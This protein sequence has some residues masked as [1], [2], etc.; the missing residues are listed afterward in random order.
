M[1]FL[2]NIMNDR[3]EQKIKTSIMDVPVYRE[4]CKHLAE[5]SL[6]FKN[7]R[8]YNE[9]MRNIDTVNF[10][11][12][13][14]Y[15]EYI[16]NQYPFLLDQMNEFSK[17]DS[18]GNPLLIHFPEIGPFCPTTLRYIKTYGDILTLFGKSNGWKIVEIGGGY[19]GLCRILASQIKFLQYA[20]VDLPETLALIRTYL[21]SF[22]ISNMKY[23][24]PE[25]LDDVN[26]CDLVISNYAFSECRKETQKKYLDQIIQF[27]DRGYMICNYTPVHVYNIESYSSDELREIMES[28]GLKVE[29]RNEE[30]LMGLVGQL[31]TWT[32]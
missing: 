19:G 5:S 28:Y 9:I 12:G 13:K 8:R 2:G 4:C 20:I 23:V 26:R 1:G 7:F 22:G 17:N 29:I 10:E 11:Y 3:S 18:V 6:G 21:E 16:Q 31:F 27:S 15:L 30:P 14:M 25:T 24:I 32:R